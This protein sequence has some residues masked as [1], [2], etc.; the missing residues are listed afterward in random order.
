MSFRRKK[1]KKMKFSEIQ[2]SGYKKMRY[3]GHD[4]PKC[5]KSYLANSCMSKIAFNHHQ[6]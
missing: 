2:S 1:L 3:Y 4:P 5:C 6:T